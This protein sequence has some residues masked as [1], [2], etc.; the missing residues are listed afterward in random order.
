VREWDYGDYEGR[1]TK[2][3]K[4]DRKKRGLG[5]EWDIWRDGCEGG[6]SPEDVTKRLDKVIEDLRERF[7]KGM[8][9][10]CVATCFFF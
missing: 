5:D 1:V 6:E 2:E 7:H 10:F 4:E 9:M 8:F 3:I